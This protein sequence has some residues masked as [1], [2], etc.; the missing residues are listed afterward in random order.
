MHYWATRCAP[1]PMDDD[2]LFSISRAHRPTWRKW[3]PII[4]QVFLDIKPELE[5]YMNLRDNKRT[6]LRFVRDKQTAQ[7]R[8]ESRENNSPFSQGVS[9]ASPTFIPRKEAGADK[10]AGGQAGARPARVALPQR[11][12]QSGKH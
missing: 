7:R 8:L 12:P 9:I 11:Y 6:T 1:F 2:T 4:V 5:H 10:A 3:K